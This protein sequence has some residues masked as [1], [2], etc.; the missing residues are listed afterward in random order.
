MHC[1]TFSIET[2][3]SEIRNEVE[4]SCV[5]DGLKNNCPWI[6][7]EDCT[8]IC[9]F[10]SDEKN[11]VWIWSYFPLFNNFSLNIL[12]LAWQGFQPPA[13][14]IFKNKSSAIITT[15]RV[16]SRSRSWVKNVIAEDYCLASLLGK[17]P[18]LEDLEIS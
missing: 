11:R 1:I 17:T 8:L 5:K 2:F 6:P 3:L 15:S 12:M 14:L 16:W 4:T 9:L 7:R 10:V 18:F 13:I